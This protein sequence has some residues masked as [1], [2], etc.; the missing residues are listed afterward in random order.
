MQHYTDKLAGLAHNRKLQLAVAVSLALVLVSCASKPTSPTGKTT[1]TQTPTITQTPAKTTTTQAPTR[2]V[3]TTTPKAPVQTAARF[4]SFYD[5][6]QDFLYRNPNMATL[7]A[8]ASLSERVISLDGQQAEFVKMPWEYVESAVS[9]SRVSQGRTKRSEQRSLLEAN[10]ARY[11]VPASV[12]TAIWGLESSFGAGMGN[13]DL[14]N[15][16]SSLAYDGRRREF[17]ENQLLAMQTMIDRGDVYAS[18]LKGSWAGGMGHTQFIPATWLE[19]GVDGNGDGKKNPWTVADALSST[20]NYLANAGWVRDLPAF[21]EVQLPSNFNY[22]L[23]NQKQ[24]LDSWRQAGVS[25]VGVQN[26]GGASMA[27]L[28][29]PAGASGPV[30]LTTQ[31][32]DVIKVYNNSSSYALA[33]ALLAKRINNQSGIIASWPYHEQPLSNGQIR[34]LQQNLSSR[35]YD[36]QGID[37]VAGANTRRAFARWQADNGRIPDGFISQNSANA[38]L[39]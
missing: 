29:L 28:W 33:V 15:A 18:Q 3:V 5:W 22:Q 8:N 19:Q 17:A 11:G 38:L 2:Q 26:F 30:L 34:T 27:E 1:T 21:Y 16:L 12:V 39:W 24:S 4:N 6:R 13:M 23:L 14:V 36:T 10:E 31:N 37:G 35:G 32:F 25:A 7:V 20:A 9:S